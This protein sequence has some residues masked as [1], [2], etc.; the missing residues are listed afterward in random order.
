M[1]NRKQFTMYE[2][3]YKS[4]QRIRNKK[5]RSD[6][7]DAICAYALYNT[8]PDLDS[9]SDAVAIA[10]EL[11]RPVLDSARKKAEN[12]KQGGSKQKAKGKQTVSEK[13]NEKEKEKEV[14]IEKEKESLPVY[15]DAHNE[16]T[17]SSSAPAGDCCFDAFW[18]EYPKNSDRHRDAA[19]A[20]WNRLNPN[21]AGFN[22]IMSQLRLWKQS[23]RWLEQDGRYIPKAEAFLDPKGEYLTKKPVPTKRDIPKGASGE[24][25][26]A[27]LAAI[28]RVLREG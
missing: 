18:L 6:A 9:A 5:D 19:V 15:S 4:L 1:E 3:I 23:E 8:E 12:G 22:H 13:E 26:E 2:S 14:E 28:Q 20:A 17:A 21:D 11:T 25:G 16:K 7:Y 10:F 24:L 27:E